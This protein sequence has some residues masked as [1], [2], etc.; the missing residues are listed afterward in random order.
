[1]INAKGP[2]RKKRKNTKKAA[3]HPK[4][5]TECQGRESNNPLW[6]PDSDSRPTLSPSQHREE[7]SETRSTHTAP[8]PTPKGPS[9]TT[10]PRRGKRSQKGGRAAGPER[11]RP[12]KPFSLGHAGRGPGSAS[13]DAVRAGGGRSEGSPTSAASA[14]DQTVARSP[15]LT[16]PY[17]PA[18]RSR[19]PRHV[20]Q[21][22]T[23]R[24]RP[25]PET[26]SAYYP[27]T[28]PF[29]GPSGRRRRAGAVRRASRPRF[30]NGLAECAYT[31]PATAWAASWRAW[32]VGR[33]CD[34][35]A[36]PRRGRG[37]LSAALLTRAA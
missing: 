19:R 33:G 22:P 13:P 5:F 24:R 25:E 23:Y 3:Q 1:M 15:R 16:L 12:W 27:P 10:A 8:K 14:S 36:P 4:H 9:V 31:A 2:F 30:R 21:R 32:G 20:A 26:E 6:P 34:A 35:W 29:I 28:P 18:V 7:L 17:L 11:P 37:V